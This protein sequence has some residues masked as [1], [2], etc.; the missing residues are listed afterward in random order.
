MS[1]NKEGLRKLAEAQDA[2]TQ[3]RI[4]KKQPGACIPEDLWGRAIELLS[5]FSLSRTAEALKL[6][7]TE[8]KRRAAAVGVVPKTFP[9]RKRK[10]AEGKLRKEP[11]QAF[12]EVKVSEERSKDEKQGAKSRDAGWLLKWTRPDGARLEIQP[13]VL[14]LDQASTLIRSFLGS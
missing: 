13:P 1:E 14:N 12:V 10:N 5:Q 8:L 6:N 11:R 2:F 7:G 3:W 4:Y 9:R